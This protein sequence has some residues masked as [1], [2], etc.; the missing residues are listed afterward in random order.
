MIPKRFCTA[1]VKKYYNSDY[2]DGKC[3]VVP[4]VDKHC[5]SDDDWEVGDNDKTV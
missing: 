3:N 2:L 1:K 5:E 4:L